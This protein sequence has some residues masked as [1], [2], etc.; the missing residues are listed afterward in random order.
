MRSIL[1]GLSA[2]ALI[3]TPAIAGVGGETVVFTGTVADT[4]SLVMT[5]PGVLALS[6]DGTTLGSEIAG[7]VAHAAV[8]AITSNG[9]NT[10]TV[11]PPTLED[12]PSKYV[13][14]GQ[15]LEVGYSG[16]HTQAFTEEETEFD[17]GITT[18]DLTV[19]NHIVNAN[20]F[21]QGSY[22]MHTVLTCS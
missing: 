19:N 12:S 17:I 22:E 11:S 2:F 10:I 7:G 6:V 15:T 20:G 13:T 1:L 5:T 9:L 16:P 21:D 8:V 14:S 3:C 18:E 4:C